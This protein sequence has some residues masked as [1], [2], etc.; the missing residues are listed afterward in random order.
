M[1]P[2][3]QF[4]IFPMAENPRRCTRQFNTFHLL[5]KSQIDEQKNKLLVRKAVKRRN[6]LLRNHRIS[7]LNRA[8]CTIAIPIF[9]WL[10]LETFFK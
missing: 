2:R 6:Q 8:L 9:I 1:K 10:V 3:A 4:S 5:V 7:V